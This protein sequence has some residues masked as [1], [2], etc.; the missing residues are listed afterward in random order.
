M[1]WTP[2][3]RAVPP[4]KTRRS[5]HSRTS[6]LES[7]YPC[8]MN[9]LPL[10]F[11]LQDLDMHAMSI[12]QP[13]STPASQFR[14]IPNIGARD[15]PPPPDPNTDPFSAQPPV[16][17]ALTLQSDQSPTHSVPSLHPPSMPIG[18]DH[19]PTSLPSQSVKTAKRL[20]A[21]ASNPA[22]GHIEGIYR[23]ETLHCEYSFDEHIS[24]LNAESGAD[25]LTIAI[26]RGH[27][28]PKRIDERNKCQKQFLEGA[29]SI[30]TK[31]SS[32]MIK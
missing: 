30:F 19:L 1:S 20:R 31:A 6:G 11:V 14:I 2:I 7:A 10:T 4:Y 12:Q 26:H 25:V 8:N 17:T 24:V 28:L 18:P 5:I 22:F 23:G 32:C 16:A 27:A 9:K 15:T 29:N 13:A 3:T 21:T